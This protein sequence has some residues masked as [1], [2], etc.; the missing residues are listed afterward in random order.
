M[1]LG[2]RLLPKVKS[3]IKQ[4]PAFQ[5]LTGTII[6]FFDKGN[7]DNRCRSSNRAF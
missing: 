3:K 2:K 4:F 5:M 7:V 1:P 6:R